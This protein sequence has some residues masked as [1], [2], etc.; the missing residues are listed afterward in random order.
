[1]LA[2]AVAAAGCACELEP[3]ACERTSNLHAWCL[4]AVGRKRRGQKLRRR[5]RQQRAWTGVQQRQHLLLR[6]PWMPRC[7]LEFPSMKPPRKGVFTRGA[8]GRPSK[9]VAWARGARSA[10]AP[11]GDT[12]YK[13][14]V[15]VE[16]TAP[17]WQMAPTKWEPLL[18]D[19]ERSFGIRI[20]VL[21]CAGHP[22]YFLCA[23][24]ANR[25]F[26]RFHTCV[27]LAV[28]SCWSSDGPDFRCCVE[29]SRSDV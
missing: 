12:K 23:H 15:R 10:R 11:R 3:R 29:S 14:Q 7:R 8:T 1:M 26:D 2:A 17:P 28:C 22:E 16:T 25:A 27:A 4:R 5:G 9:G 20:L 24:R 6:T 19:L 13:S 21:A 18:P